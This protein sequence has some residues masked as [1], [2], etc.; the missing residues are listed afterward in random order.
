MEG[1][2]LKR[3]SPFKLL[4]GQCTVWDWQRTKPDCERSTSPW[5][6]DHGDFSAWLSFEQITTSRAHVPN[7]SH[8]PKLPTLFY[9][10]KKQTPVPQVTFPPKFFPFEQTPILLSSLFRLL[11]STIVLIIESWWVR[12]EGPPI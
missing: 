9:F 12:L 1:H 8:C 7:F 2:I 6:D 10:P 4:G 11:L 5:A 3:I